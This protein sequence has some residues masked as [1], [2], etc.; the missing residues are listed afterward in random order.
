VATTRD[1]PRRAGGA[2]LRRR[3]LA[4]AYHCSVD[5]SIMAIAVQVAAEIGGVGITRLIAV[6]HRDACLRTRDAFAQK[7]VAAQ[8]QRASGRRASR[9]RRFLLSVDRELLG[10]L[11]K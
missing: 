11:K 3:A 4:L 9:L 6:N 1:R 8:W 7:A 5:G 2:W 10:R